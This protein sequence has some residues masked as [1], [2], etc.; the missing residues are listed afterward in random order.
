[1]VQ[2]DEDQLF[3]GVERQD[4]QVVRFWHIEL[5]E[6]YLKDAQI[7]CVLQRVEHT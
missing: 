5:L 7:H 2:K 3:Q 6:G 4:I 1:M